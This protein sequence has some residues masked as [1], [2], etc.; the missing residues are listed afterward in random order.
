MMATDGRDGSFAVL[1]QRDGVTLCF[2]FLLFVA[3][4]PPF[5]PSS[6]HSL[7]LAHH[8]CLAPSLFVS[9]ENRIRLAAAQRVS[10]SSD[11]HSPSAVG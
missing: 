6:T 5:R 7:E 1:F 4:L 11:F 2:L 3:P 9:G 8:L 10:S